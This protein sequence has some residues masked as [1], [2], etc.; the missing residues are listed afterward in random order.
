MRIVKLTPRGTSPVKA[1]TILSNDG[2]RHYFEIRHGYRGVGYWEWVANLS[3]KYFKPRDASDELIL[4]D[5]NYSILPI[6]KKGNTEPLK[7]KVG[8]TR[9]VIIND[10]NIEQTIKDALVLWEPPF[11]YDEIN[12]ELSDNIREIGKGLGGRYSDHNRKTPMPVFEIT[13]DASIKWFGM[14]IDP[15]TNEMKRY[16]QAIYYHYATGKFHI[17]DI[18]EC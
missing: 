9:Y 5:T 13:G 15:I 7:D 2:E 8:N 12:Y 10:D 3:F 6:I 17:K 11:D 4:S 14:G 16:M 18:E 1:K